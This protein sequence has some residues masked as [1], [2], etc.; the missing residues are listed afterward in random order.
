MFFKLHVT[1]H[2][3]KYD[4]CVTRPILHFLTCVTSSAQWQTLPHQGLIGVLFVDRPTSVN[5]ASICYHQC[6]AWIVVHLFRRHNSSQTIL[7][8]CRVFFFTSLLHDKAEGTQW[9]D[10]NV[11]EVSIWWHPLHF[12]TCLEVVWTGPLVSY[13]VD[14]GYLAGS[15]L[16]WL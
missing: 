5:R 4:Q 3:Q 15:R 1:D 16:W 8:I 6:W 2:S 12:R 10:D 14:S 7:K 9:G 13:L 11:V